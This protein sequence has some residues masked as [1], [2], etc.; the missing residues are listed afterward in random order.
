MGILKRLTVLLAVF[1]AATSAVV[2]Q[3]QPGEKAAIQKEYGLDPATPLISRIAPAPP[4]VLKMFHEA[5]MQ[6]TEHRLSPQEYEKV[7]AAFR[8]LPALHRKILKD[9]LVSI[10]FLD[11]MPN[12]ALTSTLNSSE[13]FKVFN[14]T[15]RAGMLHETVSEWLTAKERTCFEPSDAGIS[16]AID[17][18]KLDAV[19]YLLLHEATHVVDGTLNLMSH[20]T[21]H[22]N[23]DNAPFTAS[24]WEQRTVLAP[25]YRNELLGNTR[26]RNGKLVPATKAAEVYEALQQTPFV[27]LYSL[28]SN[29]EDLAE[30]VSVYHFTRKLKQPFRIIVRKADQDIYLY[31][32]MKSAL[33]KNRNGIMKQFYRGISG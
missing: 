7:E 11:N 33:V 10:S 19:L 5:G 22:T 24:I 21:D 28:S 13:T 9:H 30:Y 4:Q 8:K 12:N 31:E 32:P 17:A 26:F 27:S 1:M 20:A 18:G 3:N 25:G 6:P 15:V 2:S 29:H 14:I 23:P 16:V